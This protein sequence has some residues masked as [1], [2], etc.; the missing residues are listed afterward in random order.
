MIGQNSGSRNAATT[1]IAHMIPQATLSMFDIIVDLVMDKKF[2]SKPLTARWNV[3]LDLIVPPLSESLLR[4]AATL[5][6]LW[7]G[8]YL[9]SLYPGGK[10][11]GTVPGNPSGEESGIA[12]D[13]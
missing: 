3:L 13:P 9:I 11:V 1:P 5:N 10:L 12:I 8:V 7:N 6:R 4:S 2:S